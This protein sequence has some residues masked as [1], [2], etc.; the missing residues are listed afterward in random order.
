MFVSNCLQTFVRL[1]GSTTNFRKKPSNKP[2]NI[3]LSTRWLCICSYILL[4]QGFDKSARLCFY[5]W[6]NHGICIRWNILR[7]GLFLSL[8]LYLLNFLSVSANC[9]ESIC[10]CIYTRYLL[11]LYPFVSVFVFMSKSLCFFLA[12]LNRRFTWAFL[13]TCCPSVCPLKTFHIFYFF[14]LDHWAKN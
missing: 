6:C 8:C 13:I 12:H 5:T 2:Y 4:L 7:T 3:S 10:N 1:L 11:Y 14:L 9:I